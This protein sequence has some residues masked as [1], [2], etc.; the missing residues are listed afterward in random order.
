MNG[1]ERVL[2]L[3]GGEKTDHLANMPI[4]MTFA[5]DI[6]GVKYLEYVRDHRVMVEAQVKTAELFGFDYVP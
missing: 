1:R 3:L 6:A 5:A 2:A 4:T